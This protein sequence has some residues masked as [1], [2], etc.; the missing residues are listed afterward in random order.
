MNRLLVFVLFIWLIGFSSA[1][2]ISEV[3]MNPVGGREGIEWIE[4]YNNG[5]EVD[6]SLWEIYDGLIGPK[7]IFT[8]PSG[9]ILSEEDYYVV[10]LDKTVLNNDGDFVSLYNLEREEIDK[11]QMIKDTKA[12]SETWQLCD[13][14]KLAMPT[15]G[16]EN[17]C[18]EK[19]NIEED[20]DTLTSEI[21]GGSDEGTQEEEVGQNNQLTNDQIEVIELTPKSIKTYNEEE[22]SSKIKYWAY[23]FVLFGVLLVA[24]YILKFRPRKN[25]F[26]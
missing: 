15:K 23:S 7:N 4:L 8:I 11:T 21:I 22:S 1:I 26:E 17:D 6:I 16:F 14:W 2:K 20:S 3:E 12:G 25:E 13:E 19:E 9:I 5:G 10:E 18:W 24:L